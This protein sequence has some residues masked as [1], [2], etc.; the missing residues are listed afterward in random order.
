MNPVL[1]VLRKTIVQAFYRQ[2]AGLLL[3]VLFIAGSFMRSTEHIALATYAIHSPGMLLGYIGLWA[4]Y[5]V[6][7]TRFM[8]GVFRANEFLLLLRLQPATNRLAALWVSQVSLLVPIMA[9]AGFVLSLSLQAHTITA[10]VMIIASLFVLTTAPLAWVEH[11]LRH[12]NP[13][14]RLSA[15]RLTI[16]NRF[17]TPYNLFFIRHLLHRQPV[18]LLLTKGGTCLLLMGLCWLY[19]TDAYDIRLLA[20]GALLTGAF[21][22]AVVYQ[23]YQFDLTQ[24][25][26]LRNLPVPLGYRFAQYAFVLALLILPELF[27]LLRNSP[28]N[29]PLAAIFSVWVFAHSLL[30]G[31]F[32]VLFMHHRPPDRFMPVV[33]WAVIGFFF[34]IMYRLPIW[35]LALACYAAA[36]GLFIRYYYNAAW[37]S[38]AGS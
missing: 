26:L 33:F 25:P 30:L 21:H 31:L 6:H 23:L 18:L 15:L 34:L 38:G 5:T 8:V 3:V 35:G 10:T 27:I 14:R 1:T 36:A 12:P 11:T 9:Y 2:N 19:P 29:V 16:Q 7:A 24:L 4:V 32:P 20:L 17:T 37:S 13:D 22:G 28:A